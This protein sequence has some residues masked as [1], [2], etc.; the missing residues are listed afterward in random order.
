MSLRIEIIQGRLSNGWRLE[1]IHVCIIVESSWNFHF[2]ELALCPEKWD[3]RIVVHFFI[4]SPWPTLIRV[5]Q[6]IIDL[7]AYLTLKL[8]DGIIYS[9]H[10]NI[11]ET[12]QRNEVKKE[13]KP[14]EP[15]ASVSKLALG[16]EPQIVL[17][18]QLLVYWAL[19]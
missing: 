16:S 14:E 3:L 19:V 8:L 7:G 5:I 13:C 10:V 17:E 2:F 18:A 15:F 11:G 4:S 9:E 6:L 1:Y 12:L